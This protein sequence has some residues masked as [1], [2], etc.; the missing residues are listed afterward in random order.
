MEPEE[1]KYHVELEEAVGR[2]SDMVYRIS[3]TITKNEEDARD[4][5]QETFLR[6]VRNQDKI[7][8]EEHLKA[9]LIRVTGNCAKTTVSSFWNRLTE[10]MPEEIPAKDDQAVWEKNVLFQEMK[11]LPDK[12]SLVL[13]LYYY[14]E[15]SVKEI[16]FLLGKKE[17][18]IKTQLSR[19]RELLRKRLE[20]GGRSYEWL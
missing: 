2:Y 17:N 20:K 6:L 13:Y 12:Y 7:T 5:Y 9:W 15:Y 3:L 4:V 10:G 14:E 8:S 11:K 18:S 19:G 16:S 1:K